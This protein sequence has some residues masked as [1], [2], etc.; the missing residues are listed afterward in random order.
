M[1]AR[2]GR[3]QSLVG[4]WPLLWTKHWLRIRRL[5]PAHTSASQT[6]SWCFRRIDRR[7]SPP[8]IGG[9]LVTCARPEYGGHDRRPCPAAAASA[10][11]SAGLRSLGLELCQPHGG[12]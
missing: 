6:S 9:G 5:S 10:Q 7:E 8:P 2:H 3:L 11:P 1:G 4:H 12:D